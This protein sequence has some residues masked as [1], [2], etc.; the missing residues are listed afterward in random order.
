MK[1]VRRRLRQKIEEVP[2]QHA[3]D[4][5][6]RV[7][8]ARRDRGGQRVERARARVP[9]VV[10]EQVL[11]EQL[12]AE[13]LA[14]K[15]HVGSDHG[16]EVEENG[17]GRLVRDGPEEFRKGLRRYNRLPAACTGRVTWRVGW[18]GALPAPAE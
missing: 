2:A 12:A 17:R 15:R 16:P 6:I 13:V 1:G 10:G 7:T 4:A 3:V 8:E 11:D 18:T 5:R 9:I 14:E